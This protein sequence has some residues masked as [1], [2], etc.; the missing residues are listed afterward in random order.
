MEILAYVISF[1]GLACMISASLIKGENMKKILFLAFCGNFLVATSYLVNSFF[2]DAA[3]ISGAV[4][5]YIGSAQTIINFFFESKNKPLP[6]WLIT[7]Y[8]IAFVAANLYFGGFTSPLVYLAIIASLTFILCIGQKS[9]AKYRFWTIINML[10]WCTYDVL[11]KSFSVLWCSHIPL[12]VFSV[13]GMIIH[14]RKQK[15]A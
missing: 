8:A 6:V 2:V 9:G 10:L 5:C 14:D 12:L 3:A 7:V 15:K 11:A 4:S 13:A 1:I